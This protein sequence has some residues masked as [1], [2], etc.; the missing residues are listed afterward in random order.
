MKPFWGVKNQKMTIYKVVAVGV[1]VIV[2][3]IAFSALVPDVLLCWYET[4]TSGLM[5]FGDEP[6][7]VGLLSWKLMPF[8]GGVIVLLMFVAAAR[9]AL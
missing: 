4:D 7:N 1:A 3:F 6:D 5:A 2:C 9:N 8:I